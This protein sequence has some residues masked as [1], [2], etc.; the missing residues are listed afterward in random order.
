MPTLLLQPYL[1]AS[2]SPEWKRPVSFFLRLFDFLEL[3]SST[4]FV[5]KGTLFLFLCLQKVLFIYLFCFYF[6]Y[7][8]SSTV[9]HFPPTTL[10]C[11][12]HPHLPPSIRPPLT[13]YVGPCSLTTLPLLSPFIPLCPPLWLLS[14]CSLFQCL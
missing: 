5:Y 4:S 10:P 11:P 14:A 8:C 1:F 7:C 3:W 13:L 9:L 12:T 2:C 6:S